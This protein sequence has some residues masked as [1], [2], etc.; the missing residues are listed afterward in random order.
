[1][2]QEKIERFLIGDIEV[3]KIAETAGPSKAT[4]DRIFAGFP[5]DAIERHRSWL[6]PD[7]MEVGS[8]RLI[9]SVHGWLVRTK[10]HNILVEACSGN[11]KQ[12]PNFPD[13]HQLNIPWLERLLAAG[14]A[15]E[16]IDFVFCSHLH[17]DHVGWNTRLINGRWTP[18]FPNARYLI[19]RREFENW[20]PSTRV[21]PS[22]HFN[23]DVFG[24]SVAPVVD[25]GLAVFIDGCHQIEDGL[26]VEPSPGHTRGHCSLRATSRS[27]TG[28][29]CGDVMHIPLQLAYPDVVTHGCEEPA[30]AR[31]TRR[32]LLEECAERGHRLMPTHFARPY[33]VIRVE[34]A[35][36]AFAIRELSSMRE[37]L[38]NMMH[39]LDFLGK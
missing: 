22:G 18:T 13:G 21:L 39:D 7:M 8:D 14:C 32:G 29:F 27:E 10:H 15:P 5:P 35:G 36:R 3:T 37:I 38:A 17:V 1:M 16:D 34:A 25:A 9:G 23:A 4:L 30:V 33:S 11:H 2:A 6:A 31:T 19:S 12:R 26:V 24:D 28:I 20:I